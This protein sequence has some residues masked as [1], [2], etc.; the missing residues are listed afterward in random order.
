MTVAD[1]TPL[2]SDKLQHIYIFGIYIIIYAIFFFFFKIN[3]PN[4]ALII[5]FFEKRF[6]RT[7]MVPECT[8]LLSVYAPQQL[9]T[10]GIYSEVPQDNI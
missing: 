7:V 1:C 2:V 6:I 5:M 10:S 9:Y 8:R 3:Y 4:N